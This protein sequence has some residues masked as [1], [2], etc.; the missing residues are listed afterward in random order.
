MPRKTK[1]IEQGEDG[2]TERSMVVWSKSKAILRNDVVSENKQSNDIRG[3][4]VVT[5]I[6]MSKLGSSIPSRIKVCLVQHHKAAF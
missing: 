3:T 2:E 4:I 5:S 1:E 6:G